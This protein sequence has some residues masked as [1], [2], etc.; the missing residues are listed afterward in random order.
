MSIEIAGA[1]MNTEPG[2]DFIEVFVLFVYV[3]FC[4]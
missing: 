3:I 2:Y 4:E 1:T